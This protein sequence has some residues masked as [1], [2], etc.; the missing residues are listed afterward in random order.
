MKMLTTRGTGVCI[1]RIHQLTGLINQSTMHLTLDIVNS[2]EVK[3]HLV[4]VSWIYLQ[5][6][7]LAQLEFLMVIM[8]GLK[9][10]PKL[11]IHQVLKLKSNF[12]HQ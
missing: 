5:V 7:T 8:S 11:P 3:D 4:I 9:G 6:I 10:T 2:E 1:D 12:I